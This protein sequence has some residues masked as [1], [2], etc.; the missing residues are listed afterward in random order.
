MNAETIKVRI[1]CISICLLMIAT[2]FTGVSWNT[3]ADDWQM[4]H[5]DPANTNVI[6]VDGPESNEIL[7]ST[8]V[9][10]TNSPIVVQNT[11]YVGGFSV[12]ATS[13][14]I[15]WY[16]PATVLAVANGKAYANGWGAGVNQ[17]IICLNAASSG[18]NVLWQYNLYG[19]DNFKVD[20]EK[21]YVTANGALYCFDAN[22]GGAPLWSYNN[23]GS[24]AIANGK[25]YATG[26]GD[27]ETRFYCLNAETSAKIWEYPAGVASTRFTDGGGPIVANN[28]VYVVRHTYAPSDV[29]TLLC[30]DAVGSGGTTTPQWQWQGSVLSSALSISAVANRRLYGS[31]GGTISCWNAEG[32]GGTTWILWQYYASGGN[33]CIAN[34]KMYLECSSFIVGGTYNKTISCVDA[35]NGDINDISDESFADPG[36]VWNDGTYV[37][38]ADTYNHRIVKRLASDFNYVAQIGTQGSGND[39]F[40]RP[41]GI[42]GDGMYL[43]IVDIMNSRIVKRLASDLSYVAQIGS[44]G[45]GNDQFEFPFGIYCDGT[46]LY[47]ADYGNNRIVKRLASDLSYVAKIGS[48]GR[49]NDQFRYPFGI[50]GDG[51]YLY[52]ADTL[53]NRIVKRLASN[54]SY[55]AQIGTQGSGNDQFNNPSGIYADGTYLYVADTSNHRIVKRLTSDLN[56]IIQRGSLGTGNDQFASP[57]GIFGSGNYLYIA[58]GG[59]N[60]IVKRLTSDLSYV[61]AIGNAPPETLWTRSIQ[62]NNPLGYAINYE[63]AVTDQ[64]LFISVYDNRITLDS[65][66][67]CFRADSAPLTPLDI[68]GPSTGQSSIEYTFTTQTTDPDGDD[69]YYQWMVNGLMYSTDWLGPY[70]SGEQA[71]IQHSWDVEGTYEVKVKAKDVSGAESDWSPPHK[72]TISNQSLQPNQL[73]ITVNP[74]VLGQNTFTVTITN[75][76]SGAVITGATVNFNDQPPQQTDAN[77]QVSFTAPS[78][79]TNTVYTITATKEG[80]QQTSTPITILN[81][82]EENEPQ[83]WIY[84]L[85]LDSSRNPLSGVSICAILEDTGETVKCEQTDNAG[86]YVFSFPLGTYTVTANLQ[87]YEPAIKQNKV[88]L[89]YKAVDANFV[90]QTKQS[91]S[92]DVSDTPTTYVEYLI[93]KETSQGS[94]GARADVTKNEQPSVSTYITGLHIDP[95]TTGDSVRFTVS[96]PDGTQGTIIVVRIGEGVLADL[97]NVELTYDTG[98]IDEEHDVAAFFDIQHSTDPAWLR[99]LTTSGLYVFVRI[100]HFSTHTITISSILEIIPIAI[101]IFYLVLCLIAA[102]IFGGIIYV[103]KR[104]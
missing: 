41:F 93:D 28:K 36:G 17:K 63:P 25:I 51:T 19:V 37:Y 86:N 73:R 53:N 27:N 9:N 24:Y 43:Y 15:N 40:D 60:R 57:T 47:V 2:V 94:V 71:E 3:R 12:N 10:K 65:A 89:E 80:F 85:V 6:S 33:L 55:V 44:I 11:V 79:T 8:P 50:C 56:Y 68:D 91:T 23:I 32:S 48:I 54:L 21:L 76:Q 1:L 49:G 83:G 5:H 82:Q 95:N 104:V 84:G 20:N 70:L 59:N 67:Y 4:I 90:L 42:C 35:I 31:V 72:I 101:I 61:S 92:I 29:Y 96:A 14:A 45:S 100:P 98:P 22:I 66:I 7:W 81:H 26:K 34:D 64:K 13:G 74:T 87:G 77:G 62:Y 75:A 16:Y 58:D 30:L 102:T 38:I 78:V 99:V 18:G 69:V 88:V 97:D 46:Y 52:V 103:R 39:Q